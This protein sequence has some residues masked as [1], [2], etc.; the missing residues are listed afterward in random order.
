MKKY[1]QPT[2]EKLELVKD[3]I[4]EGGI[5]ASGTELGDG[6]IGNTDMGDRT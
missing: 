4:M 5:F 6:Q 1:L 2:M 3:G